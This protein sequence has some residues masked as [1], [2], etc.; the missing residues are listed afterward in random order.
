MTQRKAEGMLD[1]ILN[2]FEFPGLLLLPW[3]I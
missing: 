3:L 2:V 1:D